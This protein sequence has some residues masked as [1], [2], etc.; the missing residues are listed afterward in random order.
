MAAKER[1]AKGEITMDFSHWFLLL[2]APTGDGWFAMS[3]VFTAVSRELRRARAF[4][5]EQ[6]RRLNEAFARGSKKRRE[7]EKREQERRQR[8]E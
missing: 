4:E 5:R 3:W 6:A 7:R 2:C 8:E 1:L